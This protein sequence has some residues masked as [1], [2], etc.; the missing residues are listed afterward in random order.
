MSLLT[1]KRMEKAKELLL[2]SNM[3]ISEICE[4]CG[5]PDQHYFSY[6][7]KKYY[8]VSPAKMRAAGGED[9]GE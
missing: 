6:G 2:G 3:K 4:R 8:G 1:E 5:Y 7:F 9:A